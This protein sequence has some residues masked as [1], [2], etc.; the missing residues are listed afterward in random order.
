MAYY[1]K[2]KRRFDPR[3]FMNERM[4][5]VSEYVVPG[6]S[7]KFDVEPPGTVRQKLEKAFA[8]KALEDEEEA[9]HHVAAGRDEQGEID[10]RNRQFD[11]VDAKEKIKEGC[12]DDEE[13]PWIKIEGGELTA[14]DSSEKSLAD[15]IAT[16]EAW[17]KIGIKII[18]GRAD[19]LD[20]LEI[21]APASDPLPSL[22]DEEPPLEE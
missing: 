21:E 20:A 10:A 6:P 9:L 17:K 19:V 11:A 15:I 16:G 18:G 4:E 1:R 2:N 5:D 13:L 12:G 7:A 14:S 8:A 22:M 3:Y